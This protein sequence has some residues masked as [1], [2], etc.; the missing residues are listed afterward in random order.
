MKVF[1][2][3]TTNSFGQSIFENAKI[4][5][6]SALD[7]VVLR[8]AVDK[9]IQ[10]IDEQTSNTEE[11]EVLQT[12]K[13]LFEELE[14]HNEI[15]WKDEQK[16]KRCLPCNSIFYESICEHC[17][18]PEAEY[19]EEIEEYKGYEILKY[20]KDDGYRVD[21]GTMRSKEVLNVEEARKLIDFQ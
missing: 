20:S 4:E 3:R 10:H 8:S 21:F 7:I 18:N 17:L 2:S 9:L 16:S 6:I 13:R 12:A 15:A 14:P 19:V 11:Q 5:D 1:V